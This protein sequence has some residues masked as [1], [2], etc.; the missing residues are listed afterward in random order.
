MIENIREKKEE[1]RQLWLKNREGLKLGQFYK[2]F[3]GDFFNVEGNIK[4]TADWLFF[5]NWHQEWRKEVKGEEREKE[6]KEEVTEEDIEEIQGRNRKRI[7][8][9]LKKLLDNY[10]T[11]SN[12]VKKTMS[13]SEIIKTYRAI[14]SLEE[15]M[16]MTAIARGKL[17]LDT[18]RTLLPYKRLKPEELL[19]LKK[20]LNESFDRIIKLKSGSPVGRPSP[21]RG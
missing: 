1:V 13:I 8:L 18:V 14:Q 4:S 19:V 10:D 6:E 21:D 3:L 17:K 11:E 12:A 15:K 5:L 20:K 2:K 9:I 7:V 16:K